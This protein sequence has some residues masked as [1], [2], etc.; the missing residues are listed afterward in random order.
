MHS[1]GHGASFQINKD[2]ESLNESRAGI[3]APPGFF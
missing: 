3:A 2:D 1:A